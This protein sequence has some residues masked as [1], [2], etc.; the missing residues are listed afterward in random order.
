M[1]GKTDK[2]QGPGP[3]PQVRP[4]SRAA[5]RKWLEEHHATSRGVWLVFAKK[6]TKLP[7]LS[8]DEAVEEALCFGWIDSLVKSIDDRFHRQMFTPRK[9]KSAWSALNRTRA[10]RLIEAGLM[11][12]AGLA[13]ITVAKRTGQWEAN[14][15]SEVLKVPPELKRA[16]GAN[17]AAKKNWPAY[18]ESQRKM[19]L[20]MVN[21]AKRPE[22]RAR[23]VARVIEIVSGGVK[24]SQ[25]VAE[26]MG[27]KRKSSP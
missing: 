8:Y 5:W 26:T 4:T 20:Y 25:V 19:F 2:P 9:A 12:A 7:S 1:T 10:A 11:T 13:S 24:F 22:T 3:R 16:I 14:K 6:H 27:G 15:A 23:R 18:T 17:L 21:G